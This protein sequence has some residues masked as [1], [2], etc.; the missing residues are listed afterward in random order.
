M[1]KLKTAEEVEIL[2]EGG[3]REAFILS[4]LKKAVKPGITTKDIDDFARELIAA[5]G[6]EAS[7]LNYTPRGI[8]VPYPASVCVSVNEEIVH[9]IPGDRVINEGDVVTI[10]LGLKHKGLFL[11][12]AITFLVAP[13]TGSG[14]AVASPEVEKLITITRDS[15]HAGIAAIKKGAY[16]GDIGYAVEGYAHKHGYGL[17]EGLGGHGVGHKVHE[18]PEVPNSGLPRT[19]TK[20]VPGMVIAIEPM[21]TL[22]SGE[23]KCLD[24]QYTYVSADGS[25]SAHW[26]HTVFINSK[27]EPEILTK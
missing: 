4:E 5:G 1:I 16:T 3:K 20:L 7:F 12:S 2:R 19:G 21:F 23:I 9:G 22:G 10:D 24:D 13:S 15:L 27:Y 17:V 8:T 18:D 25:L 26:E 6:D 14:Q 11:D